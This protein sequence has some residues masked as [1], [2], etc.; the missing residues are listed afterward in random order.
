MTS[1]SVSLQIGHNSP[2]IRA[3]FPDAA[4]LRRMSASTG[5]PVAHFPGRLP[6]WQGGRAGDLK[7]GDEEDLFE[8][9]GASQDVK[10]RLVLICWTSLCP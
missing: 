1:D 5:H 8:I 4:M 6:Q 2:A 3:S 9:K 10:L 7:D